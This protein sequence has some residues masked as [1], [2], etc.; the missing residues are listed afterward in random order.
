M[1]KVRNR[2]MQVVPRKLITG[3]FD[4]FTSKIIEFLAIEILS[5]ESTK[6]EKVDIGFHGEG[7]NRLMQV[8]P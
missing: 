1:E 5:M 3:E 8:V 6:L 4:W 2:L 7:K